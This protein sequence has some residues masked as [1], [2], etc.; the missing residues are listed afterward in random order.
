MRDELLR[1]A[2]HLSDGCWAK[3]WRTHPS[4]VKTK[5]IGHQEGI[6]HRRSE[7]LDRHNLFSSLPL[8]IGVTIEV[9]KEEAEEQQHRCLAQPTLRAGDT[10]GDPLGGLAIEGELPGPGVSHGLGELLLACRLGNHD[11]SPRLRAVR[12]RSPGCSFQHRLDDL[13]WY[14]V[15]PHSAHGAPPAD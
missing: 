12:R 8:G 7:A 14:R 3:E 5:A 4:G 10:L 2:E 13:R 1:Q 6:L 9:A 15:A 11:E